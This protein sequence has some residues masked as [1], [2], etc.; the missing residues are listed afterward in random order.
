MITR[1]SNHS[2]PDLEHTHSI[3]VSKFIFFC[4]LIDTLEAHLDQYGL[5]PLSPDIAKRFPESITV[6]QAV[7][8]WKAIV[9]YQQH[10]E[11]EINF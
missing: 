6:S 7:A 8:T 4:R 9:S 11:R 2:N 10:Y 3:V 5:D 1:K